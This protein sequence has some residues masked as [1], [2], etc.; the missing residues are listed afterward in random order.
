MKG[1]KGATR[2][3][4][5]GVKSTGK[6]L[7]GNQIFEGGANRSQYDVEVEW[8]RANEVLRYWF[9]LDRDVVKAISR[10]NFKLLNLA[11]A[12]VKFLL[13]MLNQ[14][15]VD[16][17]ILGEEEAL[18]EIKSFLHNKGWWVKA[19]NLNLKELGI[20]SGVTD[21]EEENSDEAIL[22]FILDNKN[23]VH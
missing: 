13:K 5:S 16:R 17:G 18:C 12:R 20:E 15:L 8:E 19:D 21:E 10:G 2:V 23:L 9:L 7:T 11:K 1:A 22:N 6:A 4:N 3:S 14:D